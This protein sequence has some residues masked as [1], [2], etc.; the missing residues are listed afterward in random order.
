MDIVSHLFAPYLWGGG[1]SGLFNLIFF[2]KVLVGVKQ[3]FPSINTLLPGDCGK[4]KDF[5]AGEALIV[6]I[7][8]QN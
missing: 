7:L 8:Q 4:C 6:A 3:P 5:V 2:L 1:G